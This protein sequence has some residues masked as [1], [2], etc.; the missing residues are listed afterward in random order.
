MRYSR[1]CDV[2]AVQIART[3]GGQLSLQIVQI[4]AYVAT[5]LRTQL[6]CGLLIR[7]PL[8][9]DDWQSVL[10]GGRHVKDVVGTRISMSGTQNGMCRAKAMLAMYVIAA[11]VLRTVMRV[12]EKPIQPLTAVRP[13]QFGAAGIIARPSD[14]PYRSTKYL[15]AMIEQVRSCRAWTKCKTLTLLRDALYESFCALQGASLTPCSLRS[16]PQADH[17]PRYKDSCPA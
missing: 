17:H 12:S 7:K 8:D 2:V 5:Q 3:V 9:V 10:G 15:I 13:F 16:R 4:F 14:A 11:N 1:C 6:L